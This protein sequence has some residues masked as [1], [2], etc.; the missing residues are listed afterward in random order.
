MT[1]VMVPFM[2]KYAVDGL[3]QMSGNL[4]NLSDAPST[5]ATMATAILIGCEFPR[6]RLPP[7]VDPLG[8]GKVTVHYVAGDLS[9][10]DL[11]NVNL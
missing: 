1:N 4:L 8:R 9:E 11:F 10:G 6:H 5:V 3:N 2:F 7:G